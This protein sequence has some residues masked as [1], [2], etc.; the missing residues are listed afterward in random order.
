[1]LQGCRAQV[2]EVPT[3]LPTLVEALAVDGVDADN[4]HGY[5]YAESR[6]ILP[7]GHVYSAS[8]DLEGV[9]ALPV[10]EK[11]IVMWKGQGGELQTLGDRLDTLDTARLPHHLLGWGTVDGGERHVAK[12]S[13][14]VPA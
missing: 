9:E 12:Q 13:L 2:P 7:M 3:T 1:V 4:V 11:L 14:A 10:I 5:L 6:H 8:A